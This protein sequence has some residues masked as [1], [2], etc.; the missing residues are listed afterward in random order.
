MGSH[1]K[2]NAIITFDGKRAQGLGKFSKITYLERKMNLS[3][4]TLDVRVSY[5]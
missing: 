3:R 1:K 4:E 2:I 5:M